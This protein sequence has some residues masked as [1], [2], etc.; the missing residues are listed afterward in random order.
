M[1]ARLTPRNKTL[2][3]LDFDD[4]I[5]FNNTALPTAAKEVTGKEFKRGEIRKLDDKLKDPIYHLA[6]TKYK[7]LMRPNES[8][9][10]L[11]DANI[12]DK[13]VIIL[14]ARLADV[15][16]DTLELLRTNSVQF[17]D[18]V[19]RDRELR[20]MDDEV[21]KTDQIREIIYPYSNVEIYEDK[22]DNIEYFKNVLGNHTINYFHVAKDGSIIEV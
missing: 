6:A 5:M 1:E 22:P 19:M 16:E 7:H 11:I 17:D 13:D 14:T 21:W 4:T 18:I 8:M 12:M 3:L 15:R 2:M 9:I 10:R 20:L